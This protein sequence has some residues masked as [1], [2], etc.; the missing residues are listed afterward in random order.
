VLATVDV[1]AGAIDLQASSTSIWVAGPSEADDR[2]GWPGLERLLRVDP[3]TNRIV[4]T[5][6]STA[7]VTVGG[8]TSANGVAW[9]LDPLAGRLYRLP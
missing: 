3:A 1:G 2:R 7:T 5:I 9:L 6:R 4:D 8:M